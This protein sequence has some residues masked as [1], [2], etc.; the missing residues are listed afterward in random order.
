MIINIEIKD[1]AIIKDLSVDLYPGLNIITGETGSGKS[2]I[3]E[4]VSMA[5]GARADTDYVRKGCDKAVITLTAQTDG[6]LDPMLE[7]LG[8]PNDDPMI[9]RREIS[10]QGR[11]SCR[12]NGTA[13]P[14]SALT[15]ICSKVADIHGQYDNQY[16]LDPEKHI[17]ILDLYGGKDL[18]AVKEITRG[19]YRKYSAASSELLALRRHLAENERQ[20]DLLSFE[21][22][23]IRA[24]APVPG[25]DEELS[26]NISFMENAEK[27][28]ISLSDAYEKL[29]SGGEPA[30]SSIGEASD[31]ISSVSSYSEKLSAISERL[32]SI[33]YDLEDLAS[34]LRNVRDGSEFSQEDL[35]NSIARL[36]VLNALKRKFGGTID[37]V[38]KYAE[39]AERSLSDIEN[40]DERRS[41]LERKISLCREEYDAAAARLG[42]LR[43]DA[44]QVLADK[45]KKE[46]SELNFSRADFAAELLEKNPSENG[47]QTAEFLIS[48]N[49]GESLKPLAKVASGGELSRIMLALKRIIGDIDDIPTMI[50]DEID[51]GIS[52]ATADVVGSKLRDISKN[53]QIICITH[54]P[55]IAAKADHNYRIEK[56]SDEISTQ[57]TV[58]PLSKEER[59]EEIARL[60]SGS[61]ITDS[62]RLAAKELLGK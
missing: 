5:L 49:A 57:S 59:T 15:K 17:D 33:Y 55:Q 12:I 10:S 35:D 42:R 45:V 50:F 40:A 18:A 11:S 20:R 62:A 52:G 38:L 25:E 16:L 23:E 31:E 46:L 51:T 34:D 56:H 36:D 24:A 41:A 61:V 47:N 32:S 6:K 29:Y 8:V 43:Q 9:I 28:Y 3:I 22:S 14:L 60:L 2:V 39:N 27:I 48:A 53:H 7:D 30:L 21:L 44:A 19:A 26:D 54:L 13:V 4:A 1:F 37:S 58:V